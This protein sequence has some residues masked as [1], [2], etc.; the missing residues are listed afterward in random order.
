MSRGGASAAFLGIP[1]ARLAEQAN[2]W[3]L[4]M[5]GAAIAP[6]EQV[7]S[8]QQVIESVNVSR[9]GSWLYYDSNLAGSSDIYR[10]RLPSGNPERLTR[11]STNEFSPVPSP[12]GREVVFHS[13]RG[14]TRDLYSYP[15]DGGSLETVAA[16]ALA[17]H[18]LSVTPQHVRNLIAEGRFTRVGPTP[19]RRERQ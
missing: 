2:I 14:G 1:F 9:D 13:F 3:S 8:G 15:L 16:M 18:G 12:D 7:T 11:D 17:L 6:A 5:E 4:P 10:M 19:S